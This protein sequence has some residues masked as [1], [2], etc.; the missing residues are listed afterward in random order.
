VEELVSNIR[1]LVAEDES[2]ILSGLKLNLELEGYEVVVARDGEEAYEKIT[3]QKLDLAILDVMMPKMDGFTVCKKIRLEGINIPALFL[4]ARSTPN[5]RVQGLKL[6]DD[7]LTKPFHLEELLLRV[8]KLLPAAKTSS[9]SFQGQSGAPDLTRLNQFSFGEKMSINFQSYEIVDK[10]GLQQ[11]ISKREIML[12]KLLVSKSGEVVSR[13]EILESIWDYKV[14]PNTR[15]IDNYVLNF[16]KYFERNP[17][18][19]LHFLSVRGVGYKFV[20]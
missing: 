15:T 16:R 11:Q 1:I 2:T 17:K 10:D 5:D 13:E 3:N 12:L 4:T 7:Y 18:S 14:F 20:S 9:V 6:G 8:K 19:P